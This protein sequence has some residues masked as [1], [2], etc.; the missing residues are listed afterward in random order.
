MQCKHTGV[1][2]R[3]VTNIDDNW[4]KRHKD[5]HRKIKIILLC[6]SFYHYF[7]RCFKMTKYFYGLGLAKENHLSRTIK[8]PVK[9]GKFDD[10]LSY[11]CCISCIIHRELNRLRLLFMKHIVAIYVTAWICYLWS[12]ITKTYAN[13]I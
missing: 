2:I 13:G 4:L 5:L 10:F 3:Q 8:S 1:C 6:K 7:N 12:I 9:I 11:P